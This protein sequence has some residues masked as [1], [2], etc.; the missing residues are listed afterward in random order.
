M[1]LEQLIS[2]S[3]TQFIVNCG[4]LYIHLLF[5]PWFVQ[6]NNFIA[7]A[8]CSHWRLAYFSWSVAL[9]SE[10]MKYHLEKRVS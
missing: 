7:V 9:Y 8:T 3:L 6:N 4:S 5:S 1:Q 2:S 10:A